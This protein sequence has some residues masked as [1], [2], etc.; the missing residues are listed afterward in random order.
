M[1]LIWKTEWCGKIFFSHGSNH[2]K[3]VAIL[4]NPLFEITLENSWEDEDGRIVLINAYFN[5]F[6]FSLCNIYAP[7]NTALQK[8][9]VENLTEILISNADISNLISVGDWNVTLEAVDKKGGIQWKPSV[10]RDLLAAFMDELNL[11]DILRIKNPSKRGFT[12]E[13][14]ALK[15]KSRIDFFLISK[16]LI[17]STKTADIKTAIAPDHKAIRL[18]LKFENKKKGPGLWKFNNSLL[19]DDT[20]VNLI[21]TNYPIICRKYAYLTNLKLK[22]EMIKMEIRSLTIPY[23][24]NKARNVRTLEKQLESRIESLENKIEG[25]P[26]DATDAEQQEYER[27]KTELRRIYEEKADGVILRSKIRWIEH[28]KDNNTSTSPS[29]TIPSFSTGNGDEVFCV[30]KKKSRDYYLLLISKKAKL[31]NAITILHRDFNLS[32]KQLQQAFSLPHIVALEP[33][34]RAFQYKVLNRI[35]YTNEKLYKI[36]FISHK[37]CTFCKSASET[38]THLLYHCPFSIAFWKDFEWYWSVVKD[39]QIHLALED[40]IVGVITRPCP[41]LNYFLLIAKIY[42]WDC[43]RN[44][45]LPNI[46]GFKAKIELKYE[47]EA[48]IARKGNNIK[49]L[50]SKWANCFL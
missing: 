49:F 6:K 45:T 28:L 10:Y 42:L 40:I 11:V 43:R 31:P 25:N 47:T 4:M 19:N 38:L 29:S 41:L 24:K 20:F 33:Y 16:P 15:M 46:V 39:E 8:A 12:Y 17:S 9:F 37:D 2:Q 35:L 44:Q 50:Q 34:V 32:E 23:A 5:T 30:N 18:F 22:W 26:D 14:S 27:L 36:G 48:Y 13:S 3:G 21:T 1:K 7:N